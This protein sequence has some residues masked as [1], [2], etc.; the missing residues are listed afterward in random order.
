MADDGKETPEVI[1]WRVM[2]LENDLRQLQGRLEVFEKEVHE[3]EK[4]RQQQE[5]RNLI[6]G[7]GAL[8]SIITTLGGIIWAYRSVI[9]AGKS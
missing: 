5:R 8:G 4:V 9:F 3:K 1:R 7:I 2:E 6:A